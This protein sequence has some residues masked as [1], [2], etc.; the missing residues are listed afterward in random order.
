MT[1]LTVVDLFCGAGGLSAGFEQAGFDV[2]A[3]NDF[4]DAAGAT[5]TATHPNAKFLPGPIQDHSAEDFLKASRLTKGQLTVLVG[6][7]PCQGFSVYNHQRGLHDARSSLYQEYLRIVAGIAPEWVVLEN[8]TGMTS[9]GGG[10]AVDG[11]LAGL[12]RLGYKVESKIL[13]AEDFGVPQERRRIIF[14]GNRVGLP[15]QFPEHTHGPERLPYVTVA[16]A[17]GDLPPLENGED[18]GIQPYRHEARCDYQRIMRQG[19][20]SVTNH[21]AAKLGAVNCERLKHI[22]QGGSWRD[23]PLELLPPGMRK[24]KRSDHTKRYGRLRWDGFASTILTKCDPHWG[25][26]FH[27]VQDRILTVRE[28]ARLQSFPDHFDFRGSRTEQYVQVGNAV[29]PLLGKAIAS[30][31]RMS[32]SERT[33]VLEAA[34]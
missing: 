12:E 29:P 8:V 6:G 11:I 24:A 17:I 27:P 18:R 33:E 14:I 5:F 10:A 4:F 22:P 20:N 21:A 32:L 23:I 7:P 26:Y 3:G 31:I 9:A 19:S 2:R 16:D 30:A 28:A 25:A 15:I 34:E 1:D 13:R